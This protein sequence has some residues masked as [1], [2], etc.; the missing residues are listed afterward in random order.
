[1]SAKPSRKAKKALRIAQAATDTAAFT[2]GGAMRTVLRVLLAVLLIFITTGLMFTCIFAYYVKTVLYSDLKV[3]L[4]DITLN[5][6]STVWYTD[7]NGNLQ[8]LDTL[9]STENRIWV[10][11][12]NIPKNLEH[13]AVAIEDK[14]FY[15]HK[16][17]DWYRTVAA[18]GNMFVSMKNDFG[19]STITQ[20]LIKNIT[21]EDDITVQ[22]KLLELF[23]AL[24][25]EK[26]Y[27]KEEIMEWYLNKIYLGEG[28]YGVGTAA[29]MYFGKDVWDLSLAE[30]AS[31]IGITNNPSLYD[32]YI[33]SKRNKT[34]QE[35]ILREM[36]EQGYIDYDEYNSA[37]REELVF[38]RGEDEVY[39]QHIYSYY[40][41][42]VINDVLSD[43]VK[44]Q[45][46]SLDT[47]K[48]LLYKGGYQIYS[49][50][51]MDIQN[52]V[53]SVYQDI[54]NLPKAYRVSSQQLQSAMVIMDPYTGEVAAMA[55]GVGEKVRNFGFD[56]VRALRPPGSS[57]KPLAVYGPAFDT[58]LIT[59]ATLVK[60]D[61]DIELQGINWLPRNADG[62]YRG[63]ITIR[64]ALIS[65]LNTV[66]AQILDK[67]TLQTSYEYLT[68]HLGITSLV[69]DR[70]GKTDIAYAPLCLGQL[71]DGASVYEMT[72]AYTSFPNDGVMSYARTYTKVTD[73]EGNVI[74]SNDYRSNVAFKVNTARNLT[75]MMYAAVNS[76]TGTEARLGFMPVAGKTGTAGQST[77]RYF[78]GFTPYYVAGVWC[79]YDNPEVMYFSGNPSAQIWKRVMSQIH[80]G[81]EPRTFTA[82]SYGA[83]TNI[84][85]DLT[86]EKEEQDNPS[87]SPSPT[88]EET[89][90]PTESPETTQSPSPTETQ[91]PPEASVT[92][93][94]SV[95]PEP[96]AP[97]TPD[98][99]EPENSV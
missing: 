68:Q 80:E 75:D 30:C 6:T 66:S 60:D 93:E 85:G 81:L 55:S 96:S 34:R 79:G 39:E 63:I 14:R 31:L 25:F 1:M 13:A 20:Q 73:S 33:S 19:G 86:E 22:R 35:T 42:A 56:Y 52:I 41:E 21:G 90:E 27:S 53:D 74:L 78:M 77:D 72:Q 8:E 57:F 67:L 11:Y 88:P 10:E 47:A 49:C 87:P 5:L 4:S 15:E 38:Q 37:V 9:Y 92:P 40:V 58:G 95:V 36:Y 51:D 18:F 50:I 12:D 84:F 99:P 82:P 62:S 59:Q 16:G 70:D 69:A 45:G 7:S 61:K 65:S 97:V 48:D 23:R 64:Q 24:E 98:V 83:A 91:T 28:C 29:Q 26:A 2:I 89:V 94:Q 17:V 76:G 46:I 71:T 44:E 43:L 3:N 54:D 32:P